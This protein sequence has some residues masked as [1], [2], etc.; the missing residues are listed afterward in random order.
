MT[1]LTRNF[2]TTLVCAATWLTAPLSA[3]DVQ[4]AAVAYPDNT[5]VE[6]PLAANV[7][8]A[9]AQ[10]EAEI[11]FRNGQAEVEIDYK[12]LPPALLFSGEVT[13]YVVWA[14]ARDGA[15]ENLGELIVRKQSGDAQYRTGQKEFGLLITAESYPLVLRPSEL[16]VFTSIAPPP[17]KA[18]STPVT[19][20]SFAP[21]PRLGNPNIGSMVYSG[22]ESLDLIQAQSVVQQATQMHAEN[23]APDAMRDANISLA[24]ATNSFRDNQTRQGV[25]YA[26]RAVSQASTAIRTTQQK[27]ADEAA[28][29]AAAQRAAQMK[30]LEDQKTSAQRQ[31]ADAQAAALAAREQAL[32]AREQAAAAQQQL[33]EAQQQAAAAQQ[34]MT[35]LQQQAAAAQQEATAAQERAA[36]A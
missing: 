15:T 6:L 23:Y 18:R 35:L 9:P 30:S 17:K 26:R 25:D 29:A 33:N 7:R 8:V 12:K 32:A 27:I 31:A 16:V 36:A 5:K 13:S 21:A 2:V 3:L 14:V 28:A 22:K 19:L 1:R 11:R 4:L 20:T 24:Q 10:A 34:Q